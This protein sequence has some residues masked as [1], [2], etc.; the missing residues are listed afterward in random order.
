M[1]IQEK[2]EF[3]RQLDE[4]LQEKV[5]EISEEIIKFIITFFKKKHPNENSWDELYKGI[6]NLMYISFKQ[7]C[8]F[9]VE[10]ITDFYLVDAEGF[11]NFEDSDID[12]YVY[13]EDNLTPKDRV[14]RLINKTRE[15]FPKDEAL[16]S[17]IE[18]KVLRILYNET[19]TISHKL[20]KAIIRAGKKI[21]YAMIICGKGCDRECCHQEDPYWAPIDELAE[22]PYHPNC[23]CEIIYS[24]PEYDDEEE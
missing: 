18:K 13:N 4:T 22:P 9:T 24:D 10:Q 21:E 3:H 8:T 1:T 12:K 11:D 14:R 6:I 19:L 2:L 16:K 23:T 15:N 7:T 20:T 17:I 5:D